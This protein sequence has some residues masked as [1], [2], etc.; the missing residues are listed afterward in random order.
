M[1]SFQLPQDVFYGT[2]VDGFDQFYDA[3]DDNQ[4]VRRLNTPSSASML[5]RGAR[6]SSGQSSAYSDTREVLSSNSS[7]QREA[8]A[9]ASQQPIQSQSLKKEELLIETEDMDTNINT[10]TEMQPPKPKE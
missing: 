1:F 9:T 4:R 5:L 10:P 8:A 6:L 3:D 7:S 2:S